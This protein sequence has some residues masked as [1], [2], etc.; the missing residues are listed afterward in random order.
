[1]M[2][3]DSID[4]STWTTN[5]SASNARH[6]RSL[7]ASSRLA[8]SSLSPVIRLNPPR[9]RGN[10][11][12]E[13]A[14][15][16]DRGRRT[17]SLSMTNRPCQQ[18]FD[19]IARRRKTTNRSEEHTVCEIIR[20]LP[21]AASCTMP[22]KRSADAHEASFRVFSRRR[23]AVARGAFD[24]SGSRRRPE[25]QQSCR[26]RSTERSHNRPMTRCPFPRGRS[27]R[28]RRERRP[29]WP[30]RNRGGYSFSQADQKGA[31]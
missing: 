2:I 4:G 26:G 3:S 25:L 30:A 24:D 18:R 10:C 28:Q 29:R 23:F 12:S 13:C 16:R 27:S 7:I 21:R 8:N 14:R 31:E 20:S 6:T 22:G 15:L 19:F 11:C 9:Q 5:S 1:M 17:R